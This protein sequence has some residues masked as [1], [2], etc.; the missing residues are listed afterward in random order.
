KWT[1]TDR[2]T[3]DAQ[4]STT[5]DG[6]AAIDLASCSVSV[7]GVV[8]AKPVSRFQKIREDAKALWDDSA[9]GSE[10]E[11]SKLSKFAHFC[12]MAWRSF[13]RNRCPV[14]AAALAYATLLAL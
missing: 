7:S 13:A 6:R 11:L 2:S 1:P 8:M 14:R 9:L 4:P 12:L 5:F 3:A 10:R